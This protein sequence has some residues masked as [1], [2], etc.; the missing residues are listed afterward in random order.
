MIRAAV[1]KD[2]REI[3]GIYSHYVENT[4]VSFEYQVPSLEEMEKRIEE[5]G[6]KYAYLVLESDH[7]LLGYAYGSMYRGR[8]AYERTVEVSVYVHR[9]HLH[10]GYGKLLMKELLASL[11]KK[12]MA[13]AIAVITSE[14]EVSNKA[15]TAMGFTYSGHLPQ[16]GFKFGS[17]H[18]INYY[19]KIL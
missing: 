9:D 8:K 1:R 10:E 12:G 13:T 14:N 6:R 3:L 19:Y 11:K 17:W 4:A 5:N 15:F 18:G 7:H 16:V 2:A